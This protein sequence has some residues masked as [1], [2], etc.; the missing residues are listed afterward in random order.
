M[1]QQT[2][3]FSTPAAAP[4]WQRW[5]L[6]SLPARIAIFVAWLVGLLVA[7]QLA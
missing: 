2:L 4:R 5:L 6:F 3:A 7:A 1:Q